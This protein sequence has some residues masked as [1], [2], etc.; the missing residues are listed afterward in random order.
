MELFI[1]IE[2]IRCDRS[3]KYFF[4]SRKIMRGVKKEKECRFVFLYDT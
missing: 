3:A 1:S 2:S 4:V